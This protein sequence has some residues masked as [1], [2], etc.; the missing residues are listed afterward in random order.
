MDK[1]EER[2]QPLAYQNN[3]QL[4]L[5]VLLSA[6]D[7]DANINAILLPFFE[8][9]NNSSELYSATYADIMP[10]L[11]TVKNYVNKTNYI[12]ELAK[13]LNA[14][15]NIPINLTDLTAIKRIGRKSANVI[16]REMHKNADVIIVDLHVIRVTRKIGQTV[17]HENGNKI[18]KQLMDRLPYKVWNEIGMALSIL[19]REIWSPT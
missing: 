18:E 11:I 7:S 6:Q 19:G 17:Q 14:N 4:L 13:K 2:K 16:K 12:V 9:Y 15:D 3:Y 8:R 10:Y 5:A 1:Y